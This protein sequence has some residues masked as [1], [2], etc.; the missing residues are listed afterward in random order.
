[1]VMNNDEAQGIA[2]DAFRAIVTNPDF[3]NLKD[4]IGRELDITDEI[5]DD[6][7]KALFGKSDI[8]LGAKKYSTLRM[9][10]ITY[11]HICGI[12]REMADFLDTIAS[13]SIPTM[14]YLSQDDNDLIQKLKDFAVTNPDDTGMVETILEEMNKT[15]E[16]HLAWG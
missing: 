10:R 3:Y 1:M 9:M 8:I 14:A 12:S 2:N 5:L 6:A 11:E 16:I 7:V 13:N 15:G 4:L